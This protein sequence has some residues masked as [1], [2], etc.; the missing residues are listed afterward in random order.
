[1]TDFTPIFRGLQQLPVKIQD[2]DSTSRDYFRVTDLPAFFAAGP[3][4][5]RFLCNPNLFAEGSYVYIEILDSTGEPIPYTADIDTESDEGY[6]VVSVEVGTSTAPGSGQIVLCG[7]VLEDSRGIRYPN[8]GIANIRWVGSIQVDPSKRVSTDIVYRVLPDVTITSTTG[9]YTDFTYPEGSRGR[10]YTLS[11][12]EYVNYNNRAALLTTSG[13]SGVFATSSLFTRVSVASDALLLDSGTNVSLRQNLVTETLSDGNVTD[14]VMYLRSPLKFI[15]T[16]DT[17]YTPSRVLIQ[18]ASFSVVQS[19]SF[20][21]STENSYNL[22]NITF[23]NLKPVAGQVARIRSYYR[24]SGVGE[25]IFANEQ[26]LLDLEEGL[27]YTPNSVTCSFVI[28]TTHRSDLLDFKFEFLNPAGVSSKHIV[29]ALNYPFI[30]GNTYI[31]G[32]DNLI[33]GSLFVSGQTGTGVK[34][35]GRN[36]AALISSIGYQGFQKAFNSTAQPGFAIWSGSAQPL[37]NSTETYSGVGIELYADQ[38]AYF[39]YSTT[40]GGVLDI[41][42]KDFFIGSANTFISAS[43]GNFEILNRT[44]DLTRFHVRPNG[45]VTASAFTARTGSSDTDSYLMLDTNIGLVDGKNV[46]R[47]L[48]SYGSGSILLPSQ[49]TSIFKDG[50]GSPTMLSLLNSGS[51]IAPWLDYEPLP[52]VPDIP[53]YVMPYENVITI[54]GNCAVNKNNDGFNQA[55]NKGVTLF[56]RA[57]LWRT[58]TSS[59]AGFGT[60]LISSSS[61]VTGASGSISP[62]NP[63]GTHIETRPTIAVAAPVGVY[64]NAPFKLAIRVPPDATENLFALR[65]ETAYATFGNIISPVP[66]DVEYQIHNLQVISSRLLLAQTVS[67]V[68]LRGLVAPGD[69]DEAIQ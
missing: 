67:G 15:T 14:T 36:N 44:G 22:A 48:Y 26:S 55:Q 6:I 54:I 16:S 18:S 13:T 57:N 56:I 31:G 27:G 63:P 12:L 43:N 1:M 65:I 30:G 52:G 9:S 8:E 53:V 24:S 58:N 5:F 3:N 69:E 2:T 59:Y 40:G 35:S 47:V 20:L 25:Y 64:I 32:D 34:I 41:R 4:K 46:G 29:E 11:N 51:V 33:T 39:R 7:T 45:N 28:P 42:A 66:Y 19:G 38:S 23:N 50:G 37:L 60:T 62:I 49:N 61:F 21:S 10:T 17:E 68:N